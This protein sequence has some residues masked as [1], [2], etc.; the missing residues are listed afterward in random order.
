M[1]KN[2]NHIL[3]ISFQSFAITILLLS[4]IIP[5]QSI[6][7]QTITSED[8]R[9]QYMQILFDE[10]NLL[11]DET[12]KEEFINAM[13]DTN[14]PQ[15][16]RFAGGEWYAEVSARFLWKGDFK[17]ALLFMTI[18]PEGEGYQWIITNVKFEPFEN[19]FIEDNDSIRFQSFMHPLSHEIDFM[20]LEKV[21]RD[22]NHVWYYASKAFTPNYLSIFLYEINNRNLTFVD[23]NDVYFHFI[24]PE[25]WYFGLEY[26]N[27]KS[28][29]SGWLIN[30]LLKI[31]KTDK[32]ELKTMFGDD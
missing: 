10:N 13:T 7:A 15:Y 9:K 8:F 31:N 11:I 16:L 1:K 17:N 5:L 18:E 6:V 19:A 3:H 26:F 24:Q 29:N 25:G 28:K 32:K 22:K 2:K 14:N 12:L 4:T 30:N 21:F 20:N 23:I 27:R